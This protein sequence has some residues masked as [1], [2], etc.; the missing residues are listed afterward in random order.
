MD[1]VF[2]KNMKRDSNKYSQ[3]L[4]L[5]QKSLEQLFEMFE[6]MK[7]KGMTLS[8]FKSIVNKFA[9][10]KDFSNWK[11]RLDYIHNDPKPLARTKEKTIILYGEKYGNERWDSYCNAQSVTNTFEYKKEKYGMTKEEFNE[12]NKSR[13]V[14]LENMIA[15]HGEEEGRKKYENYCE[16]QSYAGCTKEYFIEKYGEELGKQEYTRV[17]MS[18]GHT[19]ATY[20][21][22]YGELEGLEKY[23]NYWNAFGGSVKTSVQSQN[24]FDALY[25][26]LPNDLREN[27][28]Y[29]K[30]NSEFNIRN[31]EENRH[32]FY[33]FV[34]KKINFCIEYNGD[35]WHG[36]P[37]K[38]GPNDILKWGF[39]ERRY[40]DVWKKDE[41]KFNF[42][43][44]KGYDV[45]VVWENDFVSNPEKV[46]ED[47][48]EKIIAK[49]QLG[50]H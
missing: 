30:L 41:I 18:K 17:C 33:D 44:S 13:A 10:G 2:E 9:M 38:Y 39:I 23:N 43:R 36:N 47:L 34:I 11:E 48:Y 16:R 26:K 32:Y 1:S 28:L 31:P 21:E 27:C 49:H 37:Q 50:N 5:S 6:Y 42:L 29:G 3:E 7:P 4:V 20:V 12:Y 22:K 8:K 40:G 15:R 24:L 35:F 45:Y 19:L 14:T 25:E 46:I